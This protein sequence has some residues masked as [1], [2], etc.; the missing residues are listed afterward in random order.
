MTY[1]MCWAEMELVAFRFNLCVELYI[2]CC[3][4]LLFHE[5]KYLKMNVQSILWFS[6]TWELELLSVET[7]LYSSLTVIILSL[8]QQEGR[9][10]EVIENLL[11][12]EKQ[13]RTVSS[14]WCATFVLGSLTHP[15]VYQF[16]S[17][18]VLFFKKKISEARYI[19]IFLRVIEVQVTEVCRLFISS[20]ICC[21]F[22]TGIRHGLHIPYLSCYSENVLRS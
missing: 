21:L 1:S 14:I 6:L 19:Y 5:I 16:F 3:V 18:V 4:F 20:L 8:L 9:L 13:T 22:V 17:F 7:E 2:Y 15:L 11:S 12:L 10:Q